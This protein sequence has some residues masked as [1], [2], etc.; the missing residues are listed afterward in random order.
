MENP[1]EALTS[2]SREVIIVETNKYTGKPEL[3]FT[4]ETVGRHVGDLFTPWFV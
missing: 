4:S 3:N 1:N 2:F